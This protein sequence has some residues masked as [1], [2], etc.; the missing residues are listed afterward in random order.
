[1]IWRSGFGNARFLG[2]LDAVDD[3]AAIAR[4]LDVA[5]LLDVGRARLGELAGDAADLDH[6]QLGAKGQH[7]GHLQEGAEEVADIVGAVLGEALGAIAALQQEAL[8]SA[9][10]ANRVFNRRASP[11]KTSGG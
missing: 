7:D 1:M 8:P 3:V 6:R 11:A 10:L 9:T 5:L 2:E 4:Q